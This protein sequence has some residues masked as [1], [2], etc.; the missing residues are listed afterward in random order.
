MKE[1]GAVLIGIAA[2]LR[3]IIGSPAETGLCLV[4]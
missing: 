1:K 3:R 2:E 4:A